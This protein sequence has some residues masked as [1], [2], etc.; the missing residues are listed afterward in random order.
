MLRLVSVMNVIIILSHLFNIRGIE[1]YLCDFVKKKT[2]TTKQNTQKQTSKPKA[3]K[4]KQNN[5][6]NNKPP[7]PPP[8]K[9][10][11]TKKQ[12][13]TFNVGVY[14]DTYEAIYFKLGVMIRN[15]KLYILKSVWATLT[16]FQGH[17]YMR[18][19]KLAFDLD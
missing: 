6:N 9:K 8:E 15:T 16:F 2:T 4:Q 19:P 7:P 18:N 12:T 10:T 14:S 13:Q 17:R 11:Q 1:P 5:N 3:K